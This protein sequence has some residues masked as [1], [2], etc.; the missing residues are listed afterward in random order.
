M[1]RLSQIQKADEY[2]LID[3]TSVPNDFIISG[4]PY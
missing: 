4:R 2:D 1:T 3:S